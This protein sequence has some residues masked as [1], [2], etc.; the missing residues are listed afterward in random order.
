LVPLAC[1]DKGLDE[2]ESFDALVAESRHA[3]PP[4]QAVFIAGLSGQAGLPPSSALVDS[5]LQAMV[6]NVRDGRFGGYLALSATG[7]RLTFS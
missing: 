6:K 5:A 3:S 2:L 4:W 1:V 7:E